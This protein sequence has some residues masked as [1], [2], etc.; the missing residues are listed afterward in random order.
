MGQV[1]PKSTVITYFV[2]DTVH[3]CVFVK[4]PQDETDIYADA[5]VVSRSVAGIA[6]ERF[7]VA[8][9]S[10]TDE[11]PFCIHYRRAGIAASDVVVC[12]EIDRKRLFKTL[13]EFPLP[14]SETEIWL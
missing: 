6:R 9:K 14:F 5:F 8:V 2:E 13:Q 1:S 7:L 10:K 11:F 12:Q 4:G 3:P